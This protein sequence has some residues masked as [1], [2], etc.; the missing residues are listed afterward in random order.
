M[1]AARDTH[2]RGRNTHRVLV[3]KPDGTISLERS[4]VDGGDNIKIGLKGIG[5]EGLNWI[6]LVQHGN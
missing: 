3:G 5:W 2:R 4:L 6:Y 1:R